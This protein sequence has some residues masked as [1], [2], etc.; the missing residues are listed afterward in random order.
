M[1]SLRMLLALA[2]GIALD[3]TR[4]AKT[5]QHARMALRGFHGKAVPSFASAALP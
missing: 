4:K 2:A 5:T 1:A 3:V